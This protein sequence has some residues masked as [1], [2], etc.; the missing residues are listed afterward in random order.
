M[1]GL[2]WFQAVDCIKTVYNINV[3]LRSGGNAENTVLVFIKYSRTATVIYV[4]IYF[5]GSERFSTK[6]QTFAAR[7]PLERIW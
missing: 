7:K 1:T 4:A 3:E 5:R 2:S 6:W